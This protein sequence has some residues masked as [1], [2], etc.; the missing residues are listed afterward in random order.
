[1]KLRITIFFLLICWTV[2]ISYAQTKSNYGTDAA[3]SLVEHANALFNK[4][5]YE[6]A[7]VFYEQALATGDAFF[8]KKCASQLDVINNL[9]KVKTKE[10]TLLTVS[11]DTVFINYL[12]GDYPIHVNGSNWNASTDGQEDWCK[13][14]IDRKRGIV[15]VAVQPNETTVDRGTTITVKNRNG[16]QKTVRVTN[17][18][19]PEVLRSSTQSLVFT[20]DGETNV[21]GIDANTTWSIDNIPEWLQAIK[22]ERDIRFTATA[23]MENKDRIAQ[24][25]IA[26]SSRQEITINIIQG[27]ALDSLAFSKND[28]HF[29]PEGGEEYIRVLTDATDWRFGDFP[30]WCQLTKVDS[31]MIRVR[32]TPNEPVDMPREASINVTTG[33]Q[34]LGINV[35]QDPR[36]IIQ[37]IPTDGIGGRR[38]SFGV[39]AGYLFPMIRASSGGAFTGSVVNYGAGTS[40][41]Q[42]S[43]S[44]SGGMAVSAFADIRLYKNLYLL[45]GLN[46]VHYKYNNRF[47]A[48]NI[49]TIVYEGTGYALKGP[50]EDSYNEEYSMS[51]IEIP[52]LFS[53]RFPLTKTSHIQLNVGP[54][55][56]YGLS[57]KMKIGGNSDSENMQKYRVVNHQVTNELYESGYYRMHYSGS[58]TMNLYGTHVQYAETHSMGTNA[59]VKCDYRTDTSP[60]K[61][62]NMGMKFGVAFEYSGISLGVEYSWMVTNMAD[63][64]YWDGDRWPIF[65]QGSS[66]VMSGYRQRNNYLLVK[67]GYT[68]RY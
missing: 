47:K 39:S 3:T 44:A 12:G 27:A 13:I 30:H 14:T 56:S 38:V 57:G 28:L 58:G 62:L 63:K 29:G 10:N 35:S 32:C 17:G 67:L 40:V 51:D 52:I 16:Q 33:T 4:G 25:K 54:Y 18:A 53:Y 31:T 5:K 8:S 7:K 22:G 2:P 42:V 1:M 24:V 66:T 64:K 61:K 19:S 59:T 9:I 45:A 11:Q 68:F 55:I 43:Y 37:L 6:E 23:N 36:P 41:E 49:H 65:I 46:F 15:M 60:L 21:V 26:T 20:P 34:T 48:D 50:V